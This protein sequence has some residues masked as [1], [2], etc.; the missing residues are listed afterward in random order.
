[1]PVGNLRAA[2]SENPADDRVEFRP[3]RTEATIVDHV[4]WHLRP[5]LANCV[6]ITP[7]ASDQSTDKVM[8]P[9]SSV[10]PAVVRYENMV[11]EVHDGEV[12]RG[13]G[14]DFEIM[15]QLFSEANRPKFPPI[16]YA[17]GQPHREG[18]Q[19][20]GTTGVNCGPAILP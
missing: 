17:L 8:I 3:K 7:F 16:P 10:E 2:H 11:T 5:G 12:V 6:L 20:R 19:I 18:T 15:Y 4:V 13:I 1:M 14:Y 9:L